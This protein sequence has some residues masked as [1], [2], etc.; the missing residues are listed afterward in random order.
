M[1][2]REEAIELLKGSDRIVLELD[3]GSTQE[4]GEAGN[5]LGGEEGSGWISDIL[6]N[7]LYTSISRVVHETFDYIE[8]MGIHV[9]YV[10]I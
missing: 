4:I 7:V 6:G 1:E 3:D 8:S 9:T 10:D 5:Y 2:L